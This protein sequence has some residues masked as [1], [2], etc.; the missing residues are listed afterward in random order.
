MAGIDG[1]VL[2]RL[3]RG[4]LSAGDK[5]AY[6]RTVPVLAAGGM[7]GS[8]LIFDYLR[9]LTRLGL[10]EAAT[11]LLEQISAAGTFD[12][13]KAVEA[14]AA[15]IYG[16][17]PRR[18]AWSSLRRRWSANLAA[19]EQRDAAAAA[20]VR[21]AW[22]QAADTFELH[23]CADGNY[24]IRTAGAAWP[25]TWLPF[26]DDHRGLAD[27]RITPVRGDARCASL[28]FDGIGL[29]WEALIGYERTRPTALGATS[30]LYVV[31]EHPE[32]VA[33][34]FHL[35][36][37]RTMLADSRVMW[38]VGAG[39][40]D[41][42]RAWLDAH[43][44][45]PLPDNCYV[46]GPFPHTADTAINPVFAE[47]DERRRE[48]ADAL[49]RRIEAR[50]GGRDASWWAQRFSE[51]MDERGRATDRPLRVLGLS[52]RFT[53]FLQYSMRDCLRSIE[54]LGHRVQVL[55][56]EFP[57]LYIN[58]VSGLRALVEYE[59][60]LVL[61]LSRM[62][63][64]MPRLFPET[65][66]T[67]AWDQDT[68]PWVF[69]PVRRPRL[70]PN[71]FLMG[72]A[73]LG[74]RTRFGWP[75]HRCRYCTTAGSPDTYSAEP[76][77][78]EELA[79]FRCDV[80]YVSHASETPG[81]EIAK[82]EEWFEG[83]GAHAIFRGAV[84]MLMPGWLAG[85]AC[86][87]RVMTA[88]IDAAAAMH[89]GLTW[90]DLGKMTGPVHRIAGRVF[91]HVALG[92]VADWVDRTGRTFH[93][94]GNGWERH[95]RLGRYARGAAANGHTLR[96]IYQGSRIN[97]QLMGTGFFHQRALDG[98][99]AGGFFLGRRSDADGM[100]PL[101]R[102]MIALLDRH[103]VRTA[104]DLA[105][106]PDQDARE[107]IEAT[108]YRMGEDPRAVCPEW[109]ENRR[110]TAQGDF[111]DE[112]IPGL[113]EILFASSGEFEE[114]AE[115]FLAD[116]AARQACATALRNVLIQDYS[117]DARMR[118]MLLFVRDGYRTEAA[119]APTTV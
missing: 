36:D 22:N 105:A 80:S 46:C 30:V 50:Y 37:W 84:D 116:P 102:E 14:M 97:L 20:L 74:C 112:R 56:E 108:I 68:L 73:A 40:A 2:L 13:P 54:K 110:L 15:P 109:I 39:A 25:P 63:D 85:G 41:R 9:V 23:Q 28:A 100:G 91:R 62:R 66:P 18:I 32:A 93:L 89:L 52:S 4:A 60:D 35:H 16:A 95:P 5:Y 3:A 90:E 98:L 71:D 75:E 64:E 24:Q 47:L 104:V 12:D 53:T 21:E 26:L 44:D 29:G 33:M 59:P 113:D 72:Y 101:V 82:V 61:L 92:W 119:P 103:G 17:P 81:E 27:R 86:P 83:Q 38:F 69:D 77:S 106:M 34:A 57:Y 118:Q 51:A 48:Q 117:Y 31:E 79:P 107:R 67:V 96:C 7:R 111:I 11:Q 115:H 65:I 78:D 114:K 88:V 1:D 55:T 42:I 70:G 99:M 58:E 6:C 19:F 10:N 87:G 43:P 76:L 8:E 49:R 45:W 94:W